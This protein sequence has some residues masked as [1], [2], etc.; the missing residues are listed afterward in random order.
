MELKKLTPNLMVEDVRRTVDWYRD[1]LEFQVAATVPDAA[2]VP[3]DWAMLVN[4]DVAVMFQARASLVEEYPVLQ[5]RPVGGALTFYTDVVG[6]QGWYDRVKDQ[7]TIVAELHRTFYGAQEFA[8]QDC[9]GY[10]LTFAESAGEGAL[11]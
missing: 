2:D 10:V 5:D 6:L 1:V 11:P 3:W 4:G 9:N 7:A 8:F